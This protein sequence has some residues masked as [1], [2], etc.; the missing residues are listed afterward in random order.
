[1][2]VVSIQGADAQSTATSVETTAI[3]RKIYRFEE[4][5]PGIIIHVDTDSG[6]ISANH[7]DTDE[8][9]GLTAGIHHGCIST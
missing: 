6:S 9:E 4:L 8:S 5:E 7:L 3:D 2:V 1:M